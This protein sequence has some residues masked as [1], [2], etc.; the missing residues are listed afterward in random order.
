VIC[1]SLSVEHWWDD[2]G[3]D[4]SQ[5]HLV[6]HK[7]HIDFRGEKHSGNGLDQGTVRQCRA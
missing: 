4:L 2:G 6:H 3:S 5:C 7:S 1:V